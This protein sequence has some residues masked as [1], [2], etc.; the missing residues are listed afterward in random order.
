M[1]CGYGVFVLCLCSVCV[2]F[3]LCLCSVCVVHSVF[4]V[5]VVFVLLLWL[6]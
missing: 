4:A 3:V 2:V 6:R 5:V 1:C